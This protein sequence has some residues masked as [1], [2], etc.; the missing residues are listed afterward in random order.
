MKEF[1]MNIPN[2]A[3]PRAIHKAL[4]LPLFRPTAALEPLLA[5]FMAGVSSADNV[6]LT[7]S[8]AAGSTSFNS[9]GHW[10]NPAVPSTG[11]QVSEASLFPVGSHSY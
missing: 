5:T 10:H 2:Q 3:N 7:A 1:D 6:T 11:L 4:G 8:E 9:A